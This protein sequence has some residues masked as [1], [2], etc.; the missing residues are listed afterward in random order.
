M[1]K[2]MKVR[3]WALV[4]VASLAL[5]TAAAGEPRPRPLAP[6]DIPAVATLPKAYALS[7]VFVHDF[8][9]DAIVDGRVAVVDAGSD[10]RNL[11][12]QI[13]AAQFASMVQ[14]KSEIYVAETFY[15][16]LTRGD[17]TDVLTIYDPAT[18]RQIGEV[19]L[20]PKRY[21]VV[22]LPNTFRLTG[23]E[24]R[25]LV[26][27]FT[28]AASVTVVD[29]AARK[30]ENEIE[31]PGC[32]LVYPTGQES[33][34]TLCANGGLSVIRLDGRGGIAA[35]KDVEA[36]NDIDADPMFM[37]PSKVGDTY[38][39]VTFKGHVRPVVGA[40]GDAR[41]LPAFSILN[42]QDEAERWRPSGWQITTANDAGRLY[43]LLRKG[44]AEGDH[45]S[46][47]SRV[48]VVDPR[49]H[50]RVSD[51]ELR[52]PAASIEV[53]HGPQPLLMAA[54]LTGALDI[55]DATTGRFLRSL[56]DN[57]VHKAFVLQAAR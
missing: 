18:L 40:E 38:Y 15:S 56:G 23:D 27:N 33:F 17:R 28:P 52:G 55:Y 4:G 35:Q 54:A 1:L 21:Q 46:G 9:T 16:R 45:K 43:V 26:F 10:Q 7:W 25:A 6:E 51:I 14:G 49:S 32:S 50:A 42:A 48:R 30:V 12:G 5:S 41:V 36:F 22:T 13:R 11:K 19:V 44:A 37:I 53:T 3:T 39:F 57:I 47:G 34:F 29:L 20:P 2:G 31:V 24:K 8:N